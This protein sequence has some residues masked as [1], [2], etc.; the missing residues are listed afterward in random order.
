MSSRCDAEYVRHD[1]QTALRITI[2]PDEV[3]AW[4]HALELL[5]KRLVATCVFGHTGRGPKVL[6]RIDEVNSFARR[7]SNE[8][9]ISL[10]ENSVEYATAYLLKWFSDSA[11]EVDHIDLQCEATG[12]YIVLRT[13]GRAT[14]TPA[15]P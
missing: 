10:T 14:S 11:P 5:S 1:G 8:F 13:P 4:L 7:A 9:D 6:V 15:R 12:D 3:A 2:G